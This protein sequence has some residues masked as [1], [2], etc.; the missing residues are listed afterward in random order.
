[1]LNSSTIWGLIHSSPLHQCGKKNLFLVHVATKFRFFC[2]RPKQIVGKSVLFGMLP[3]GVKS[4]WNKMSESV[5][6]LYIELVVSRFGRYSSLRP[7]E[8]S[9]CP[10]CC[11]NWTEEMRKKEKEK[12]RNR[13]G[14]MRESWCDF[15]NK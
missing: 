7:S 11:W 8:S 9:L 3:K 15:N 10:S 2:F 14:E 13:G 4:K 5:C 12:E 1:L 6:V